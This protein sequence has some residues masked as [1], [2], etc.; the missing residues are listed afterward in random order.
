MRGFDPRRPYRPLWNQ[1]RAQGVPGTIHAG[2][3]SR[4]STDSS[5]AASCPH[6]SRVDVARR[7]IDSWPSSCWTAFKLPVW[8]SSRWPAEWRALCIRS[9]RVTPSRPRRRS[10]GSDTTTSCI[11]L[12]PIGSNGNGRARRAVRHRPLHQEVLALS[13]GVEDQA[14]QVVPERRVGDRQLAD[15]AALRE[16]RQPL[17]DM[18]EVLEAD[19]P[20]ATPCGARSRAAGGARSG[21]A[22]RPARR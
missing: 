13:P 8:S 21:R 6:P 9:P 17:A 1:Q 10:R 22:A 14:L 5:E 11:P 2:S 18:V 7:L 19:L 4:S 12:W 3:S 15:L 16:D 20:A